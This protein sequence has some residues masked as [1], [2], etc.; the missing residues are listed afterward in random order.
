IGHKLVDILASLS[1]LD[2][3]LSCGIR[4]GVGLSSFPSCQLL[5]QCFDQPTN[6]I[7][8]IV[9]QRACHGY[10][11]LRSS[12]VRTKWQTVIGRRCVVQSKL[13]TKPAIEQKRPTISLA[14]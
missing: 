12:F 14:P 9:S 7:Y 8:V 5:A 1:D 3:K 2:R 10:L 6:L 11:F 4:A 13:P